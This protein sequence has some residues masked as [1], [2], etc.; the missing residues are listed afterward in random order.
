MAARPATTV[1][2]FNIRYDTDRDEPYSW[3]RRRH[4][5]YQ[6]LRFHSPDVLL[7]QEVLPTQM[8]D[9]RECLPEYDWVY[10]PRREGDE[11]CPIG[12]KVDRFVAPDSGVYWL[13]QTPDVE[14]VG[15]DADLPRVATWAKLHRVD[16]DSRF[17]AVSVHLDHRG[18]QARRH[19]AELIAARSVDRARDEALPLTIGGDFNCTLEDEPFDALREVGML[20][21]R[22]TSAL[23]PLGPAETCPGSGFKVTT[24]IGRRIDYILVSPNLNVGRFATLTDHMYGVRPSDHLPIWCE[25]EL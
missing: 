24:D 22:A 25:L 19:S 7:L 21:A 12:F 16:T 9:I 15:W 5:V 18:R 20:D 3:S 8:S 4:H 2:S 14:S 6:L 10:Q 17:Y 1:L 11:A 13:S 23:P